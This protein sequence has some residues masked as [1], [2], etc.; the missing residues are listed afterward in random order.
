MAVEV[1]NGRE[2]MHFRIVLHAQ[3]G[4]PCKSLRQ[5][6]MRWLSPVFNLQ[7]STHKLMLDAPTGWSSVKIDWIATEAAAWSKQNGVHAI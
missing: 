5:T 6:K 3:K 7:E 4:L 1:S 2:T